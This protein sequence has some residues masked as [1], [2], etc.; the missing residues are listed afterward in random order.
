M[1]LTPIR[2][3]KS[4]DE[5]QI[6]EWI[7][8]TYNH[9]ETKS[10]CIYGIAKSLTIKSINKLINQKITKILS[11]NICLDENHKLIRTSL[12]YHDIYKLHHLAK[13]RTCCKFRSI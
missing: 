11:C 13:T 4:Y 1:S 2:L 12:N 9:N 8:V 10:I 5:R 6:Q 7:T 3:L